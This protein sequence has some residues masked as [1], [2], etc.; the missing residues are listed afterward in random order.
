MDRRSR[1][2]FATDVSAADWVAE[3]IGPSGSGVRGLVPDV[4]E[5]YAR[6][7]H[8]AWG[9]GDR[10]VTWAE[11]AAWSGRVIH[12]RVQF[13]AITKPVAGA[14]TTARPWEEE[15]DP[16][17]LAPTVLSGLVDALAPHTGTPGHCWFAVW[18]G[19]GEPGPQAQAVFTGPDDAADESAKPRILPPLLPPG[20]ASRPKVRWPEHPYLLLTGPLDAAGELGMTLYDQSPSLFWPDDRAWLVATDV[21]LDSTYIGGSA[22]LVRDLLGDERLEAVPASAADPVWIT[23]DDI[24][25]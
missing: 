22:A 23:S 8:P 20:M 11:V 2:Q 15:P 7:L 19:Y 25:R 9:A 6:V 4:F 13:E 17:T 10:Q 12:P 16:G 1:L 5:A 3:N 18:D 21:D 24:N 14:G